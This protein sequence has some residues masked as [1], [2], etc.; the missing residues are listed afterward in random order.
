VI[1]N[2]FKD[3]KLAQKLRALV[4]WEEWNGNKFKRIKNNSEKRTSAT[5]SSEKANALWFYT[6]HCCYLVYQTIYRQVYATPGRTEAKAQP[7]IHQKYS[8]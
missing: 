7:D 2:G 4:R 6:G 5:N 8:S 3:V 1:I